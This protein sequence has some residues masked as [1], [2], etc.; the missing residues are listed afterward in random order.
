M[1]RDQDA[2]DHA[3]V[4][5]ITIA[6]A[7]RQPCPS[8]DQFAQAIGAR[9]AASG[10]AALARLERAGLITIERELGWRKVTIVDSRLSASGEDR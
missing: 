10:A 6:A 9:G 4:R 8:N 5:A 7:K 3:V 2:S 1:R